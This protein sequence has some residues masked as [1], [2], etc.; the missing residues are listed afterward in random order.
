MAPRMR[1]SSVAARFAEEH[2]ERVK[3]L[4]L[5]DAAGMPSKMGDH[6]PLAFK[7]LRSGRPVLLSDVLPLLE[8]MGVKVIDERPFEVRP[9]G[10]EPYDLSD[11][12]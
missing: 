7:L 3:A 6:T 2:P 11:M 4:I 5:V 9:K 12:I 8:N 10:S 1:A